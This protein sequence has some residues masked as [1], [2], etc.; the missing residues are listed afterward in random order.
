MDYLI[1]EVSYNN[2]DFKN[3]CVKLDQFQNIIIPFRTE[4]G[5]TALA[6][7]EKLEKILVIYYNDNAIATAALKP[8]DKTTAEIARVY[9][10]EKYR[11]KGLAK[12]LIDKITEFAKESGYKKLVLDTWKDSI[13][14]RKL[15]RKMGFEEVPMFDI[16]TLKNSFSTNDEDKLRKIQELLVFMEKDI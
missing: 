13:S 6:G 10:D 11:G 12:I 5:L 8:V 1:K 2:L 4:L 15:Y 3:L 7:L 16:R 14:A 9:T